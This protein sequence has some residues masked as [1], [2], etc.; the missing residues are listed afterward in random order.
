MKRSYKGTAYSFTFP[1]GLAFLPAG[2]GPMKCFTTLTLNS[3][4]AA[5]HAALPSGAA[6]PTPWVLRKGK[7]KELAGG[8]VTSQQKPGLVTQKG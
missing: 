1:W 3:P 4:A 5:P 8:Q 2:E 7:S 6:R